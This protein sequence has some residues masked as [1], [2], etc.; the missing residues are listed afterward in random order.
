[1]FRAVS[2]G[3]LDIVKVLLDKGADVNARNTDGETPL[4]WAVEEEEENK[5]VA[6]CL[7][8]HGAKE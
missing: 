5:E 6:A 1:M 8:Q 2:F 3:H 4:K 7:R